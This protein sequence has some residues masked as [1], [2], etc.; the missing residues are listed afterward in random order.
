VKKIQPP[1]SE[2]YNRSPSPINLLR[3]KLDAGGKDLYAELSFF[4]GDFR[5][6]SAV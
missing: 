2:Y 6:V 3:I 4:A 1:K 5:P